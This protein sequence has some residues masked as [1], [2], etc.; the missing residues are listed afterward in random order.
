[1]KSELKAV[2]ALEIL[3]PNGG[4]TIYGDDFD[5]I[6]YNEGVEPITKK[7]FDDALKIAEQTFIAEAEAKA[8]AKAALLAQLGITEEQAKLL[9]N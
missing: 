3:L 9:L 7:Q 6:V 4:W 2:K 5:T 1:M 8:Q